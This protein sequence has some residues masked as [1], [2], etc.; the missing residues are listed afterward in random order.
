[1]LH[2]TKWFTILA[3]FALIAW[4][5]YR[6]FSSGTGEYMLLAAAGGG[7]GI[8]LLILL[9]NLSRDKSRKRISQVQRSGERTLLLVTPLALEAED[10]HDKMSIVRDLQPAEWHYA[11]PK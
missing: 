8:V 2:T 6:F 9:L 10:Y 5:I 11:E 4:A 3:G 7:I 1:M